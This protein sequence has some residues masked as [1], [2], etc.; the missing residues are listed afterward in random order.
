MP[1]S[2]V[3]VNNT[4]GKIVLKSHLADSTLDGV[5]STLKSLNDLHQF[6]QQSGE[7]LCVNTANSI[8]SSSNDSDENGL[9]SPRPDSLSFF[10]N[11]GPTTTTTNAYSGDSLSSPVPLA[12]SLI[13]SRFFNDANLSSPLGKSTTHLASS[14][15]PSLLASSLSSSSSNSPYSMPTTQINFTPTVTPNTRDHQQL[16]SKWTSYDNVFE[17]ANLSGGSSSS[18]SSNGSTPASQQ[19]AIES[20]YATVRKYQPNYRNNNNNNSNN[21]SSNDVFVRRANNKPFPVNSIGLFS[22]I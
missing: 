1:D 18:N 2:T 7:F 17:S 3:Q 16:A 22:H 12:S 10:S 19:N 6:D 4:F 21:G 14:T 8:S 13:A 15:R 20:G 5:E 11:N 9:S